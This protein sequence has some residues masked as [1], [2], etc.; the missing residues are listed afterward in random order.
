[1]KVSRKAHRLTGAPRCPN[2]AC[3]EL[4]D[5]ASGVGHDR[6][7]EDGDLTVCIFCA[8]ISEF[9]VAKN[10]AV[11]LQAR[12]LA[13]LEDKERREAV[14]RTQE[15]IRAFLAGRRGPEGAA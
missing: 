11:S 10:G 12:S 9:R 6:Q 15:Q 5:G 4:I 8:Q 3:R 13:S 7:P 14:A 1:M 2:G